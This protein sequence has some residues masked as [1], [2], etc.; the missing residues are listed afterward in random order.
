MPKALSDW[1]T[2]G[3]PWGR[4]PEPARESV[5]ARPL[6]SLENQ[7]GA[8][9]PL[10]SAELPG[11]RRTMDDLVR[12]EVAGGASPEAARASVQ[13]IAADYDRSVSSGRDHY[14]LRRD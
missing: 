13:R 14:P 9:R 3:P 5:F 1:G 6:I 12:Q 8:R 11:V 7:L 2:R 10:A 4:H